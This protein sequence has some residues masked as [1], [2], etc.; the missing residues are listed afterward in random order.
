[1]YSQFMMHGQKNIKLYYILIKVL[2][3]EVSY[4]IAA[5]GKLI[6]V[7]AINKSRNIYSSNDD[8]HFVLMILFIRLQY[9]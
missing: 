9:S 2:F 6:V 1:M 5:C 4:C 8:F 3:S 7:N